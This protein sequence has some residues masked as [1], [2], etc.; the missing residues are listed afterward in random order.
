MVFLWY[1]Q[2]PLETLHLKDDILMYESF[3]RLCFNMVY[4]NFIKINPPLLISYQFPFHS[5]TN[6]EIPQ[7][8]KKRI[9]Q[10]AT[11]KY[12]KWKAIPKGSQVSFPFG[13]RVFVWPPPLWPDCRYRY[14]DTDKY[15]FPAI[16]AS[17]NRLINMRKFYFN[18]FLVGSR[19]LWPG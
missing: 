2:D 10:S 16:H 4:C 5:R 15:A 1:F 12:W 14:G 13:N 7:L 19:E 8:I 3:E 11:K 17:N 9:I 6:P 18:A